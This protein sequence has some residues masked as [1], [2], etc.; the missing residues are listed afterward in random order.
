MV[1][2]L[3]YFILDFFRQMTERPALRQNLYDV[4]V[5]VLTNPNTP[6]TYFM[7]H[8]KSPVFSPT[9]A[10]YSANESLNVVAATGAT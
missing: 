7:C 2:V 5:D 9:A 10:H 3:V 6:F 1:E 4:V 8:T